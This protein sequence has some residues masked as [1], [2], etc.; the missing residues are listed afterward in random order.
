MKNNFY[1]DDGVDNKKAVAKTT[2]ITSTRPKMR[3]TEVFKQT[4]TTIIK[5]ATKTKY[6]IKIA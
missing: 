5:T 3:T 1:K 4:P 6:M 2:T